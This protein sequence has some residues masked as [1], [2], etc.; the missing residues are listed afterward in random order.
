M[1]KWKFKY[2][3]YKHL[4]ANMG[5]IFQ[6]AQEIGKELGINSD[7]KGKIGLTGAISGCH[8]SLNK[9]VARKMDEAAFKVISSA[10]LDESI[11]EVVKDV[12]GDEYDAALVS[13]C[14][15]GLK[16]SFEVLCMPPIIGIGDN[17]RGRYIAFYERF[18]HHPGAYGRPFPPKYKDL[19]AEQGETSGEYGLQAKRVY[20]LDTVLVKMAGAKFGSHGLKNHPIPNLLHVNG[21]ETIAKVKKVSHI[22]ADSLVG[23]TSLGYDT[24]G[25]GYGD[26]TEEGIP[27]IQRGLADIAQS[28]D[29]PY[30]VDNAWGAPFI[31]ADIRK[32]GADIMVYSMDKVTGSPTCGLIIGKE[33]PMVQIRR[34]VGIHGTRY[35]ALSSHGKA[36]YVTMDP[37]KEAL[38][39]A[40][41]AL[42]IM[43]EEPSIAI[44]SFKRLFEIVEEEFQ[45]LN[46]ALANGWTIFPSNNSLAVELTYH[47]TWKEERFGIPIFS[48]EDMYAG[49]NLIQMCLSHMGVMPTITFDGGF[50]ISNGLGNLDENGNLLEEPTRLAI[51]ALFKSVELVSKYAGLL[52]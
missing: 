48:V 7:Y 46:P 45:N 37:G 28:Y 32:V 2:Q 30:I 51:K 43:K 39:G 35:G 6:E 34:A 33:E 5:A 50:W 19:L 8:G 29:V 11:R 12:Y 1:Q 21:E 9:E 16:V 20:N 22:H 31:G 25:Y 38:I 18:L 3:M 13:T 27:I 24:P 52:D 47:D 15:A 44:K 42:Q 14:E 41:T 26:K 10:S 49:T 40:L 23:F 4:H 17:Y 36:A